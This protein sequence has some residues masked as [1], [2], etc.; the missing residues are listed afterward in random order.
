LNPPLTVPLPTHSKL[1]NIDAV[2]LTHPD[3]EHL[4]ALPYLMGRHGLR[5]LVH[6]YTRQCLCGAWATSQCMSYYWTCGWES[7]FR[8]CVCVC[9]VLVGLLHQVNTGSKSLPCLHAH[10]SIHSARPS[11]Q[12]LSADHFCCMSST[13]GKLECKRRKILPG[14]RCSFVASLASFASPAC[15]QFC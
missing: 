9:H 10:T 7:E 2:L 11:F 8:E 5:A 14:S 4:G 6:A 13:E 1:P 15:C 12:Q 3:L